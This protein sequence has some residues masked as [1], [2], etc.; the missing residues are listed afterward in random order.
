MS[1]ELSQLFDQYRKL[2]AD[3]G[4]SNADEER[5]GDLREPLTQHIPAI[6]DRFRNG[7]GRHLNPDDSARFSLREI[8]N[9]AAE[10]RNWLGEFC[11]GP[12]DLPYVERRFQFGAQHVAFGLDE[13]QT[14]SGLSRVRIALIRVLAE[15]CSEDSARFAATVE[16]LSKILDMDLAI[17][18]SAYQVEQANL[19]RHT[20]ARYQSLVESLPL[21]FFCKDLRGR[22]VFGNQRC[23]DLLGITM[24]E[25]IGKTDYDLFPKELADKF[26]AD[27][28]NVLRTGEMYE[29]VEENRGPDGETIYVHVLKAPVWDADG[30]IVGVQG[31]FWDVSDKKR[32]EEAARVSEARFRQLAENIR[33]VFWIT[34]LDG[35]EMIY[36][37][38][39]YTEIWGKSTDDLYQNPL[40]WLHS[41]VEEDRERVEIAFRSR[42]TTSVYDEQYRILRPDG[43]IRW[44]RD[45]GF[46][47]HDEGGNVYRIAG[48][49]EDITRRRK[50]QEE[51]RHSNDRFRRLVESNIIGIVVTD[52][53]KRIEEANDLFLEMVGYTREDLEDGRIRWK[54][55]TPPEYYEADNRALAELKKNEVCVPWEKEYIRKDGSRIP[56]LVGVTALSEHWQEA[57]SFIVDMTEQKQVEAELQ[58]ALRAADAAN[59]AKG[60]FLANMS[61]EIRTPMNAIIGMSELVLDTTLTREQREYLSIVLD[62]S[63]AL[64]K[65]INDILDF[66]KIE[67]GKLEIE[68]VEFGLRDC[69]GGAMKALAVQA[70]QNGLELVT[71][72]LPG[73]PERIIGDQSRL[74]QILVNL[75]GN[76]IKFTGAGQVVVR[77]G[78]ES[79]GNRKVVIHVAVSDTGEG[80]PVEKQRHIFGAF[81]QLDSS[82]ARK[83]GGTGLGLAIS[84]RL[85]ELLG[86]RIWVESEPGEGTTFHFTASFG[87]LTDPRIAVD[88]GSADL[89]GLRMLVVD[90]NK[91]N[92]NS[93]RDTLESWG[94]QPDLAANGE[95]AIPLLDHAMQLQQPH[96]LY[97]VDA[98]MPG[99]DGF[100]LCETIMS[101]FGRSKP[102][103]IMMLSPGDRS[104]DVARCEQ[105]GATAYLMKPLNQSELLDTILAVMDGTGVDIVVGD[106]GDHEPTPIR[107]LNVLLVEDSPYNQKL[108]LGLLQKQEHNVIVA[109]NGKEAVEVSKIRDFD[110][111]LMDVQM[112]EM[113]GLEATRAIRKREEGTGQH[114]P[115]IAMTAQA[116]KGDKEHCLEAGMD[117]YLA[118]PV[119]GRELFAAMES[120]V[121]QSSQSAA[122]PEQTAKT[123]PQSNGSPDWSVALEN[124]DQDRDLL[125]IVASAFVEECPQLEALVDSSIA[126]GDSR[127]LSRAA[128]T[129]KGGMR[130]FGAV[131][132][133]EVAATMEATAGEG[134]LIKAAEIYEGLK[135]M[136]ANV[137][138]EL[139]AFIVNPDSLGDP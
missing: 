29:D 100:N 125:Q 15:C 92:L 48:V 51:L 28:A 8:D 130:M 79:T 65:L 11:T 132:P 39:A 22:V 84:A 76:A 75:I 91:A 42:S 58:V 41:I 104:A 10:L 9:L 57:I 87:T 45:R 133:M 137:L 55:L 6:V 17:I 112:P 80:I 66:S 21:H 71:H 23:C 35:D 62:S 111:I 95:E 67:A 135:P 7:L 98:H 86:G 121:G 78:T 128:H 126:S 49:A 120:L 110:L 31:V 60:N 34:S 44:I 13:F 53:N 70:H 114:V 117:A 26:T 85:V 37:S 103:L 47:V 105:V 5:L 74:R 16:S 72:I 24:D 136:I 52:L 40:Q 90:D 139:K 108:A 101:Q 131:A 94:I 81:E 77:V 50:I 123:V 106:L 12:Y 96:N 27:D 61:H 18:E 1:P 116:M 3:V 93:I 97:L 118:K 73:V 113:D 69:V 127:E 30:N 32:A 122:E 138:K 102:P 38:P 129:I 20:E 56:V 63:E 4:W 134:N 36:V 68:K 2:Q 119:R 99:L 82:M 124:V 83:F 54:H 115:I 46:P 89:Q 59:R 64:L 109:N 19:L 14:T 88:T 107:R 33:E 25:F 43:E